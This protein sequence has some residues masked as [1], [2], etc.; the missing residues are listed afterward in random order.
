MAEAEGKKEPKA[1][2]K[3]KRPVKKWKRVVLSLCKWLAIPV[4]CLLAVS[5]GMVIGYVYLGK[6]PLDEVYEVE[7]WRHIYDLVFSQT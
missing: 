3:K 7:T 1:K 4:S 2:K 6:R 5:I